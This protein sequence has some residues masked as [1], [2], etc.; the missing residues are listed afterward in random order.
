MREKLSAREAAAQTA[1][2]VTSEFDAPADVSETSAI[3]DNSNDLVSARV[4]YGYADT[5]ATRNDL[6]VELEQ[7]AENR[8]AVTYTEA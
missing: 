3:I 6:T 2:D 5:T 1:T 4:L 7:P 8:I